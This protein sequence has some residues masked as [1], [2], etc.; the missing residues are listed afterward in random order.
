MT[1]TTIDDMSRHRDAVRGFA[2]KLLGEV[3]LAEDITQ[4][5]FL[6]AQRTDAGYRGEAGE[7]SWLCAIALNL[8]RDHFRTTARR[9]ETTAE[10]EAVENVAAPGDA[11]LNLLESEMSSCIGEFLARLPRPQYDVVALHDTAG[12]GHAE[13]AAQL[14]I[15]VANSRVVL[16]R[17]RQ[18]LRGMFEEGCVLAFGEDA[19]P[20]E[21]RPP[22]GE[23]D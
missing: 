20:C 22:S 3:A 10:P 7:K 16:H 8:V 13:I 11:E 17:G 2:L 21:R 5:T 23:D 15:S 1:E 18:A 9:P 4:E 6:R 14:D 19:F 12:L